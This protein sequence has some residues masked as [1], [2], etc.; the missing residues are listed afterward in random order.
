MRV[1]CCIAQGR[2]WYERTGEGIGE[3][4]TLDKACRNLDGPEPI[5]E[6]V[7]ESVFEGYVRIADRAMEAAAY[8]MGLVGE[9]YRGTIDADVRQRVHSESDRVSNSGDKGR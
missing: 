4:E 8:W 6:L 2:Q 1:M 3:S 7:A 9:N 5:L